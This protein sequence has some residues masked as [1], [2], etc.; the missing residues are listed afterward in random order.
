MAPSV[1]DVA[2]KVAN[3]AAGTQSSAKEFK[4]ES[5]MARVLGAGMRAISHAT[6]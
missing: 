2:T 3:V 4:K 6:T 1:P 5:T